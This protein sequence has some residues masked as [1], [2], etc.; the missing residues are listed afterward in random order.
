MNGRPP[1]IEDRQAIRA[2]GRRLEDIALEKN[3]LRGLFCVLF[4]HG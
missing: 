4:R 1:P 3:Q 2:K